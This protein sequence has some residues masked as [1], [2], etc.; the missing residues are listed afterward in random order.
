MWAGVEAAFG[1]GPPQSPER[2]PTVGSQE[3]VEGKFR[4]EDNVGEFHADKCNEDQPPEPWDRS[5]R[6]QP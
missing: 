4:A 1:A 3:G 6:A 5:G 2:S